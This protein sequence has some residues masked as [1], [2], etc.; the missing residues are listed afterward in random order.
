VLCL[1][2][3]NSSHQF[4]EDD[5]ILDVVGTSGVRESLTQSLGTANR[6]NTL[7]SALLKSAREQGVETALLEMCRS[8]EAENAKLEETVHTL[9]KDLDDYAREADIG[10][11][12]PH[13]RLAIV[14]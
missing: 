10:K 4:Q 2:I 3:N 1:G 5:N 6:T 13:Y 12:I 9:R 8:L 14:R 11:L 7:E